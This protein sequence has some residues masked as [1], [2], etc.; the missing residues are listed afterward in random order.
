MESGTL[1]HR[2]YSGVW[3]QLYMLAAGLL[4]KHIVQN[5]LQGH[6]MRTGFK[7]GGKS[8]AIT[9]PVRIAERNCIIIVITAELNLS[10]LEVD[11]AR[12]LLVAFGFLDLSV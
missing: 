7:A 4:V 10:C 9:M 5:A 11:A 12:F 2:M 1:A 3:H 8:V 6:D